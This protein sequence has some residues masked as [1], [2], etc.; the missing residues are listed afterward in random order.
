[1]EEDYKELIDN[2]FKQFLAETGRSIYIDDSTTM[3]A[4]S[5]SDWN[6]YLAKKLDGYIRDIY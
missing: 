2:W 5:I 6:L 1:M 4:Q 3:D